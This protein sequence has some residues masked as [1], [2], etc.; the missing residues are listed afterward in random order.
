MSAAGGCATGG[1]RGATKSWALA[2]HGGA[3][4]LSKTA[5]PEMIAEY[6]GALRVA[7]VRGVKVLEDGGSSLDACETVVQTLEEHP[8]FNAGVG[9]AFTADGTHELDACVM[10]GSNLACGAVA[11]VTTVK[12]PVGLARLVMTKTRHVLLA[13]AGA[14]E[15][16]TLQGVPRVPNSAFDTEKRRKMLEEWRAE[17]NAKTSAAAPARALHTYGTVGCVALD[18]HGNLAAATSTGGL[19]GKRWGRIGDAPIVG[20]GTYAN[21]ATCAV[22]CTGTGEQFIRHVI[23]KTVSDRMELAGESLDA[24]TRHVVFQTL[25]PDDGG[26]IAVSRSGEI[27]MP[28]NSEGMFRGC[29][30]SSGRFE[31]AIWD[32]V[33]KGRGLGVTK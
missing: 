23:A 6:E 32:K 24:A 20:A 8:G 27:A 3:G 13:G 31:V 19:T 9:A 5:A 33:S 4:T 11:G 28:F 30:N 21:N 1:Q 10:D 14:E 25:N 2:I 18:Q 12:S 7:L 15:F 16:A 26:L 22:S 17:Q 29:A